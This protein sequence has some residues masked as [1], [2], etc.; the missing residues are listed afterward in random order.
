MSYKAWGVSNIY[1]T[2][3]IG[4]RVS[5]GWF[6]EIGNNV[7]I[8][9]DTRI[10]AF[11]FIPEMVTIGKDCFIGP[12]VTFTNDRYPS[13]HSPKENW[14]KTIV[15]DGANIGAGAMILCGVT[16]GKHAMIGAGTVVTKN[17]PANETWVGNPARKIARRG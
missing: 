3:K 12:R 13:N 15:E 10:G 9:D 17:V 4:D 11:C 5:I 14:E 6:C 8:G 7:E 16:I 1:Q 2:A